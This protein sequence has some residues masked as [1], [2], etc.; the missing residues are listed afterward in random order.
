VQRTGTALC[1]GCHTSVRQE[2][3]K[4]VVHEPVRKG[5]CV[6]CHKPHSANNPKGLVKTGSDLCFTCHQELKKLQKATSVHPPFA[7][8]DCTT[9]HSPHAAD[10]PNLL[11]DDAGSL[12]RTCHDPG[13]ANLQRAHHSFP[14]QSLNCVSCH[15]PHGSTQAHLIRSKPHAVFSGCAR[16]HE[17]TGPK[18]QALQASVPDLCYRCHSTVRASVQQ[19]GVHKALQQP[20]ACVICHNPHSADESG[21]IKG[22]DE[23]AVCLSCHKAI[24]DQA[25][26]SVSIHPLK[27]G[28]GRC[29]ICHSPHQSGNAHLL[30][31]ADVN[32]VCGKCHEGHAQFGHPVGSNVI[33]PRTGAGLT[34][35]SCHDPHGT[36]QR[37][38]L[39]LDP[40]R[41]LC[42]ECHEGNDAMNARKGGGS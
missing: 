37:M 15:N 23:R 34:C 36:Q 18:P 10:K 8:G 31:A 13:D 20:K 30:K 42:V 41:A 7:G 22:G 17:A 25:Q 24:K 16:C 28:G 14:A 4:T 9:C 5:E 21:L 19:Q 29:T 1:T 2:L 32:A 40:Q 12:C 27:A 38:T 6:S 3:S 11:V 39:R 35:L 33:D 26:R